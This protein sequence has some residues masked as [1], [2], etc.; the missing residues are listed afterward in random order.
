M[1]WGV[2]G[3]GSVKS[4]SSVWD[5]LGLCPHASQSGKRAACQQILAQCGLNNSHAERQDTGLGQV[6]Q[7]GAF[8]EGCLEEEAQSELR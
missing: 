4:K 7:A 1:V 6:T 2:G 5:I 3:V 8:R